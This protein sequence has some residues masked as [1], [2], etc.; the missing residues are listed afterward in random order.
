MAVPDY[1]SLM[2]PVLATLSGG[3]ALSAGEVRAA[4]S[5][6]LTLSE[7]DLQQTIPSG[8]SLFA[9]RVHWA[10]TYMAQAGLV[11]RPRRGFLEITERGREAL[12]ERGQSINVG[13]LEAFPEFRDFKTRARDS[14]GRDDGSPTGTPT[15]EDDET[16]TPV[17]RIA[18]SVNEANAALSQQLLERILAQEPAFLEQLVLQV[19]TSM[20]YG[21]GTAAAQ[22]LGR[23]GDEGVDG[24]IR[25][26]ALGLDNIYVQAKRY[27][28]DKAIGRPDIQAFVGALHGQ[29]ADRGVFITTSRF[30]ADA[31]N[32]ADRVSSRIVLL[33]GNDLTRLMLRHNVGVE[34]AE[35]YEIKRIDEDYFAEE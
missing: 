31:R 33:D 30:S 15:S 24:V 20:G 22:R 5:S 32:Y 17:E 11:R 28:P 8:K 27:Q 26:D 23:T 21:V 1:Q 4:V 7:A 34:V 3:Q 13:Y 2:G 18:A 29:N 19:L 9:N 12:A 16:A 14:Q 25:Q 10:A 6:A 35:T